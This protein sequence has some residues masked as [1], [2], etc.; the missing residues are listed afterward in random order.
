M[1]NQA[2][3]TIEPEGNGSPHDTEWQDICILVAAHKPIDVFRSEILKPIHVG[4]KNASF[5]IQGFLRDDAG[6][7]ISSLNAQY[8]ELTAQ[9]WAWKNLDADYIGFCHYR[10]YFDF[11]CIRHEE[12]A[13]GEIIDD[14]IDSNSQLRYG[15]DDETIRSTVKDFDVV[16]TEFKDMN[17]FPGKAKSPGEQWSKSTHLHDQDL[18][19]TLALLS[20]RHPDYEADI[21][22]YIHGS[23]SCFCNMFIMKHDMFH[24]YCNWVFPILEQFIVTHDF[25]EYDTEAIRTPGHL[26]ERLLNIYLIHQRRCNPDLK[27]KQ[28]QCVHFTNPEPIQY[29]SMP[30]DAECGSK[31]IVP[32][33]FAADNNY[34]PMLTCTITSMLHNASPDCHYDITIMTTDISDNNRKIMRSHFAKLRSVTVNFIDVSR[35]VSHYRLDTNNQHIGIETYYRFLIQDLLPYYDKV[36]YLDSDLIIKGDIAELFRIDLGSNLVGAVRDADYLG[37]LNQKDGRRLAYSYEV[38]EMENPYD[39]F[40]AGVL[41][42][43]TQ[44][45]RSAIP[46]QRWLEAAQDTRYIYNDQ[47]I[48]NRYC[49]GRVTYLDFSWNVMHDGSNRIVNAISYAPAEV[50]RNYADSRNNENIIHYAGIDKPW[51]IR[52]CDRAD[53]YWKYARQTPFYEFL[54][55]ILV[56]HETQSIIEGETAEEWVIS[57]DSPFRRVI[58]PLLPEGSRRREFIRIAARRVRGLPTDLD[59]E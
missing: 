17:D 28:V 12:N 16:T 13:W 48:L 5:E 24:D 53:E 35:F 54:V 18:L 45:L 46:V 40:Q 32:V 37:M 50:F 26:A 11:S 2:S 34:V 57:Q 29:P 38:L 59:A 6:D 56:A 43:N 42:L 30:T 20:I 23:R 52:T 4:A 3:R 25:S 21:E 19:D 15:L 8:C 41:L 1:Q 14:Y 7:N 36:A 39:Y 55:A 33:A 51:T 49:Q 44:A 9:Y 58:D 47:D 31:L 27:W 22:S 10:R